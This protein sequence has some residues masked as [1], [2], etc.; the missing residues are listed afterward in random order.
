MNVFMF[1]CNFF[2]PGSIEHILLEFFNYISLKFPK[3]R[4]FENGQL[5]LCI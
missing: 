4:K 2:Q 1:G 3:K 5:N